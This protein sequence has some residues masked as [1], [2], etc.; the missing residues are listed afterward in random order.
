MKVLE[1][2]ETGSEFIAHLLYHGADAL[3]SYDLTGPEKLAV[4]TGDIEWIEKHT[5]PLTPVQKKSLERR[6]SAEIW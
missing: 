6:L 2:A 4:L 1:R 5:G 3:E